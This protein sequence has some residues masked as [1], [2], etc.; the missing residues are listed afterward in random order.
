MSVRVGLT[1]GLASGKS[2]VA[3]M[4][5][6]RGAQMMYAD[7][8]AHDLMQPGTS[9]YEQ[10]VRTFGSSI[11]RSDRTI[12]RP[13]LAQ[14]AFGEHRIEEL[15]RIVHPAVS[16][17]MEQWLAEM[18]LSHPRGV[19][20]FEA[21]LILEAGI[22]KHFDK[23]V[24]VSSRPEQKLERFAGRLLSDDQLDERRRAE[25]L[26]EAE[27]RIG[28]QL[29]ETEKIAAADYVIDNSGTV[30]QTERQVGRIFKE[31]KKLAQG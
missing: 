6:A 10:V 17:R 23:I 11:I 26:R 18:S 21:A 16:A 4:F 24:V 3:Q 19:L 14:I 12:D 7:Q 27:R 2:T 25:A 13:K 5:A 9:V 20:V 15:N 8:V 31:L 1:G 30:E 29:S 22:G 28:V